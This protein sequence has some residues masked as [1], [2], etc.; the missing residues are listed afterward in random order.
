MGAW[1][2]GAVD[3]GHWSGL[4][5]ALSMDML[6][7]LPYVLC[8]GLSSG[9]LALG[10]LVLDVGLLVTAVLECGMMW[11]VYALVSVLLVVGVVVLIVGYLV[12]A[13]VYDGVEWLYEMLRIAGMPRIVGS[14]AATC[15]G[16]VGSLPML[17]V[18]IVGMVFLGVMLL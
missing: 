13:A 9:A 18:G 6:D 1:I 16:L 14:V 10:Q 8:D 17:S 5:D 15:V 4:G 7:A 12:T 11:L 2:A 3:G